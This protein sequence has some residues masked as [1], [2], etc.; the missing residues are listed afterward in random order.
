MQIS[1]S[2]MNAVEVVVTIRS[3]TSF[4]LYRNR[5]LSEELAP[6]AEKVKLTE[7]C[8]HKPCYWPPLVLK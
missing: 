1:N 8:H 4:L 3:G 6:F 5:F 7:I 2:K